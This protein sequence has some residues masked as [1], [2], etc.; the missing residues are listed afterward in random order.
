MLSINTVRQQNPI[1]LNISN[2]V[3]QQRVADAI[4]FFGGSPI[5]FT[6]IEETKDLLSIAQALVINLGSVNEHSLSQAI[7]A[8]QVANRLGI[9]V[10]VDPVAV[11]VTKVRRQAFQQLSAAVNFTA[12]R[13]NAGEL[14]YL[15]EIDWHSQGIDAGQGDLSQLSLIAQKVAQRYHTFSVLTGPTDYIS[16][17]NIVQTVANGH[18]YFQT[19]VGSGDMLDGILGV[20]LAIENSLNSLSWATGIFGLAGELAGKETPSQPANFIP[21]V[22]NQLHQL[23]DVTIQKQVKLN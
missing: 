7:E 18:P 9:P 20:A 11:A 8:G 1:V 21:A 5:M 14:A 10:V 23:D 12:I 16:D 22:L 17:G 13:G 3:T 6:D 2:T 4:S 19:N 15:A